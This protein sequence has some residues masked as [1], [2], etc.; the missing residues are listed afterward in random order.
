MKNYSISVYHDTRH[1][2]K[3]GKYRVKVRIYTKTPRKQKFYPTDFEF[4]EDEFKSIWLTQKPR[5]E[6]LPI[7]DQIRAVEVHFKQV[8]EQLHPFSFETFETI[9]FSGSGTN[10][11]N[12]LFNQTIEQYKRLG[13]FGSAKNY[14]QS[15][16]S[17]LEFAGKPTILFAEITTRFLQD[18][19]N[20]VLNVKQYRQNTLA[21]YIRPLRAIF[22]KAIAENYIKQENYPFG[23]NSKNKYEIKTGTSIKKALSKVQLRELFQYTPANEPEQR[24]LDFFFFS[25]FGNGINLMDIAHLQYEN[26]VPDFQ[27]PDRI[28]FVRRKTGKTKQNPT[29]TTIYLNDQLR[30]ILQRYCTE[31]HSPKN[32]VFDILQK[33]DSPE[34]KHKKVKAFNFTIN[35]H[36]K[37]ICGKIGLPQISFYAAR[38]S[39]A[40]NAINNGASMEFVSKSLSH[41]S[42]KQTETYFAGFEDQVARQMAENARKF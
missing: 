13:K 9:L 12:H 34:I 4:S 5:K 29:M 7:R 27:N 1:K 18:F 26:I 42:L 17:L 19:E 14:Y 36:L 39:F 2:L 32:Y 22:N 25:Y 11:I 41:S 40:T 21:T 28:I 6:H 20:Y 31:D 37:K 30:Q 24:I 16:R 10:D 33:S 8:A 35:H 3:S 15:L 23:R 38:H